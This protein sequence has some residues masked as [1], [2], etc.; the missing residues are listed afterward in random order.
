M[1]T[2]GATH[3]TEAIKQILLKRPVRESL[4]KDMVFPTVP[5][6]KKTGKF[7]IFDGSN[8]RI[9]SDIV[10]SRGGANEVTHNYTTGT[11][12]IVNHGLKEWIDQDLLD[13]MDDVLLFNE[14]AA[15][16]ENLKDKVELAAEKALADKLFNV[17]TFSGKT[18]ALSGTS[19]WDDASSNPFTQVNLASETIKKNCGLRPN[20][21]IIGSE[22]ANALAIHPEV[23]KRLSDNKERILDLT[24]LGKLFSAFN[25]GI[26]KVLIGDATHN[27]SKQGQT[28]AFDNLWGKYALFAY[29][30]PNS[31][32]LRNQTLGKNF[33]MQNGKAELKYFQDADQT[34][35]GEWC[36]YGIDYDF[37]VVSAA[38]G[39][40]FSTVVS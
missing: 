14:R 39:Y 40:L 5:V 20:T 32:T 35:K 19:R 28:D 33:I 22:V 36:Y 11:Y 2:R 3:T 21:L 29:I 23:L 18:S 26:N 7:Y 1:P 13:D 37:E 27:T 4:I 12:S 24:L 10:T 15:T 34:K 31:A 25:T 8:S 6:P 38:C 17:T 16:A 30:D 9:E